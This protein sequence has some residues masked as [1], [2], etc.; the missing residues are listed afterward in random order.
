[1]LIKGSH[2]EVKKENKGI[3]PTLSAVSYADNVSITLAVNE[4]IR[5]ILSFLVV[6]TYRGSNLNPELV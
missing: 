2:I 3:S 5:G 4:S 6:A 1:M